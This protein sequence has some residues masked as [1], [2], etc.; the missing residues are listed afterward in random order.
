MSEINRPPSDLLVVYTTM[1]YEEAHIIKGRLE[2]DHIPAI[3][4]REAV[5]G[6]LGISIGRYG[7]VHVL[8]RSTDYDTA[9]A[10]LYPDEPEQLE[11]STES[12]IYWW[13][14]D[15]DDE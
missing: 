8:V 9:I 12:V 6:A 7:E 1:S 3:I 13:D 10:L 11:D 14:D 4:Q 15:E 5:A 2:H